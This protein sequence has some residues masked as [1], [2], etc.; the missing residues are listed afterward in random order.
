MNVTQSPLGNTTRS[1][2]IVECGQP[3]IGSSP[4]PQVRRALDAL[5]AIPTQ[6]LLMLHRGPCIEC[7]HILEE[8]QPLNIHTT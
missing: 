2:R 7:R 6:Q 8:V 4:H 5:S 1:Q 3:A